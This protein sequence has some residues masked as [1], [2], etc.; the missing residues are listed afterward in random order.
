MNAMFNVKDTPFNFRDSNMYFIHNLI[1]IHMTRIPLNT[2]VPI[3]K[4]CS[5]MILRNL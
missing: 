4:S 3:N 1:R 2:T 5:Q